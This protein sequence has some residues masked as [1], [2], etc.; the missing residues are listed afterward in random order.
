MPESQFL[1]LVHVALFAAGMMVCSCRGE[2]RGPGDRWFLAKGSWQD[3]M[4][5]IMRVREQLE[6]FV[7]DPKYPTRL[8]LNWTFDAPRDNGFPSSQDADLME[9]FEERVLLALER[10]LHSL[11]VAVV[12]HN[13]ERE[14][15]FYTQK[16]DEAL[17]R[18]NT[19]LAGDPPYPLKIT[20]CPDPEWA[21][22]K[23]ILVNAG[24][25]QPDR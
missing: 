2:P 10:N 4:P 8:I 14:W 18:I 12:T 21:E 25:S 22:Y 15:I 23:G 24:Y 6:T 3:D 17:N 5:I 20:A 7:G 11:A 19:L 1:V 13:G 9:A 16:A